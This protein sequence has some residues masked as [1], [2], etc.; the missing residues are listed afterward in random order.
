[1]DRQMMRLLITT[2]KHTMVTILTGTVFKQVTSVSLTVI[3]T[4]KDVTRQSF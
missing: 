2:T 1:M 4:G 3:S